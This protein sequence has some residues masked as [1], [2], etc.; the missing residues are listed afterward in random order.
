MS[1]ITLGQAGIYAALGY[2]IVFFGLILLMIVTVLLGKCFC[3]KKKKPT[4]V[5]PPVPA[6]EFPK[7]PGAAGGVKL[8]GVEPKTAAMLLR[9]FGT[10][11]GILANTTLIS[12]PSIRLSI[13][14]HKERLLKNQQP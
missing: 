1:N 10:L 6:P 11:E 7:A 2:A 8:H 9:Q 4:P 14:Q 12:K 5:Q 13:L 3:L